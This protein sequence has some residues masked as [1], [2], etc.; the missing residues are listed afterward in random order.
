MS[1]LTQITNKLQYTI[2]KATFDPEAE[3][4]AQEQKNQSAKK[5]AE[6]K[7]ALESAKLASEK[8]AQEQKRKAELAIAEEERKSRESFDVGRLFGRIFG[9][10]GI[11]LLVFLVFVLGILGASL[12]TNLN[13]YRSL[14]YRILYAIY[15]FLFFFVVIPYVYGYRYLWK[16]KKP[17]FYGLLPLIPYHLDHPWT[18]SF[19]SWLSYKPDDQIHCLQEWITECSSQASQS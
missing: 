17:R 11:M 12:A 19:F 5:E 18:A 6:Q 7:R 16:G 8:E 4:F 13:L 14:P 1:V 10:I 2:H 9:V 3:R 15:G